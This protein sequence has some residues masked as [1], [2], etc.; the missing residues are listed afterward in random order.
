MYNE[1]N[2]AMNIDYTDLDVTEFT[3]EFI[4]AVKESYGEHNF[5]EV[6][7]IINKELK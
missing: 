7:N 2:K 4:K 5:K 1:T 3:L 6:L